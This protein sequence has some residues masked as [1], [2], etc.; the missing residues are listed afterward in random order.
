MKHH[1][2]HRGFRAAVT[3]G[4]E[5]NPLCLLYS[6]SL[7]AWRSLVARIVRDDEVGGSNPLAPTKQPRTYIRLSLD[8]GNYLI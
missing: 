3:S 7:G 4:K 1:L 6:I 8:W 2:L 5:R